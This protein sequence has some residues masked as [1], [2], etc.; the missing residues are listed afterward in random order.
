MAEALAL[1]RIPLSVTVVFDA[2]AQ[3]NTGSLIY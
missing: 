2:C 1:G 3:K